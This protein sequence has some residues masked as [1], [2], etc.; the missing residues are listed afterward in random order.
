MRMAEA[1]QSAENRSVSVSSV[2]AERYCL[3]SVARHWTG[4]LVP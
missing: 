2:R 3:L 4:N 1:P